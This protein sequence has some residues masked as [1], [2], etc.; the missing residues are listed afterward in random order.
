MPETHRKI[1]P[2]DLLSLSEYETQRKAL[3]QNLIPVKKQRRIEVGPFAASFTAR[4][5][6][7][8]LSCS[9]GNTR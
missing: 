9:G 1:T 7:Q 8:L 6:S 5:G 3:K 2:E 4:G